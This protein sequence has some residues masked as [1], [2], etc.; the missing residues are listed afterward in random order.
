[1]H[2][3]QAGME[4][5]RSSPGIK[6]HSLCFLSFSCECSWVEQ[7]HCPRCLSFLLC[8]ELPPMQQIKTTHIYFLL[9]SVGQEY[10]HSLVGSHKFTICVL[11]GLREPWVLFPIRVIVNSYN[12]LQGRGPQFLAGGSQRTRTSLHTA[13]PQ[14]LSQAAAGFL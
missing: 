9:L 7:H 1:M 6:L 3:S 8:N 14:A 10:G 4:C 2:P 5:A 12:H 11:T 13:L